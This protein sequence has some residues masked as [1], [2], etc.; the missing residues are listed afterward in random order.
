LSQVKNF[1]FKV[2]LNYNSIKVEYVY[3]QIINK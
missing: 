2:F 3:I 1:T